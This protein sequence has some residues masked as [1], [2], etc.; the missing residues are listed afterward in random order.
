MKSLH[1][2]LAALVAAGLAL[3]APARGEEPRRPAPFASC[4]LAEESGGATVRLRQLYDGAGQPVKFALEY[5]DAL[6]ASAPGQGA[7]G[8]RVFLFAA[9]AP[10]PATLGERI[11]KDALVGCGCGPPRH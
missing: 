10:D 9:G 7:S 2:A 11:E 8:V 3:S 4:A 5:A 1:R 6:P